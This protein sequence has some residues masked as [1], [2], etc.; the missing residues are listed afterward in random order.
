MALP[1][2]FAPWWGLFF[3]NL[4]GAAGYAAL[5]GWMI[6]IDV[7]LPRA[8]KSTVVAIWGYLTTLDA[9]TTS[10]SNSTAVV[11]AYIQGSIA[12]TVIFA[13]WLAIKG[14]NL[15]NL[16]VADH[17]WA[18]SALSIVWQPLVAWGYYQDFGHSVHTVRWL[19]SFL[20]STL[21]FVLMLPYLGIATVNTIA[22]TAGV[23]AAAGLCYAIAES[24]MAHQG[25]RAADYAVR[26][27]RAFARQETVVPSTDVH[28]NLAWLWFVFSLG[29][30]AHSLPLLANY[31]SYT[32]A[33]N[34][35]SD[36]V[37]DTRAGLLGLFWA[38]A[39]WMTVQ[40][41]HYTACLFTPGRWVVL[42]EFV[43]TA[44]N[45]A[46]C[47][48]IAVMFVRYCAAGPTADLQATLIARAGG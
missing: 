5:V 45:L 29:F 14:L 30:V 12:L 39:C 18:D 20:Q 9:D 44:V 10:Y 36:A 46:A 23:M 11:V 2:V 38:L 26:E 13:I 34:I 21:V 41:A 48:V 22:L 33:T 43:I 32:F 1:P 28:F 47:T 6:W 31:I 4:L 24:I 19:S 40:V 42:K 35:Y 25:K 16:L 3:T 7:V 37:G 27:S 17:A 8:G 15:A